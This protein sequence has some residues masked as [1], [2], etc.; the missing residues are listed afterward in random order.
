MPQRQYNCDPTVNFVH[1]K[2]Y[3]QTH[4]GD[5]INLH[6]ALDQCEQA[7]NGKDFFVQQHGQGYTICGVFKDELTSTDVAVTHGHKYGA[8]CYKP[9]V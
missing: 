3:D 9:K 8:V 5:N 7:S 1:E 2:P 6:S 4:I